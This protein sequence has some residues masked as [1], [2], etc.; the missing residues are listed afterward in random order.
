MHPL[1]RDDPP[2]LSEA[3]M[4]TFESYFEPHLMHKSWPGWHD[5]LALFSLWQ[6]EDD[7]IMLLSISEAALESVQAWKSIDPTCV[8]SSANSH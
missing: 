8:V 1:L 3:D 2:R 5:F 7:Y 4:L 6:T